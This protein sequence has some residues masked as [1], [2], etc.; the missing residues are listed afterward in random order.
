MR[1]SKGDCYK[2]IILLR[3]KEGKKPVDIYKEFSDVPPKTIRNWHDKYLKERHMFEK[4]LEY[5]PP[6]QTDIRSNLILISGKRQETLFIKAERLFDRIISNPECPPSAQVA[7]AK[8]YIDLI[9][10]R[11]DT[12]KHILEEQEESSSTTSDKLVENMSPDGLLTY[13]K[14]LIQDD[15]C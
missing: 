12:A 1:I 2:D 6:D 4:D 14:T 9:K 10:L 11:R 15:A 5:K 13:Y 3:F 8:G 7:A